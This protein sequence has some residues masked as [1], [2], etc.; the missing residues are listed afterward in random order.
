MDTKVLDA[1]SYKKIAVQELRSWQKSMQRRPSII[2]QGVREMQASLNRLIPRRIQD[3]IAKAME[4]MTRAVISG[5]GFI[6]AN[7]QLTSA[8]LADMEKVVRQ[9]IK[10][11]R[12]TAAVEGG[13]TGYGGFLLGLTDLPLWLS[14]K[15]KMLFEIAA[16]YGFDIKDPGERIYVLYIFQITFSS[17]KHRNKV[18]KMM[19]DWE[20]VGKHMTTDMNQHD[21]QTYWEEYRD[22]LDLAKLL[23]LVPGIGAVVG[24]MVNYRLTKKLGDFAMNA[25]RMRLELQNRLR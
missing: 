2:G 4:K 1:T 8:S 9:K 17:Q 6:T 19:V 13:V 23:Q 18:F 14:I 7:P 5:A 11:Y 16:A 10:F 21:W 3:A 20:T 25:Y 24:S 12:S 22:N 15:M